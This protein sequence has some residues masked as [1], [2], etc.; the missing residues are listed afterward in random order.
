MLL[1]FRQVFLLIFFVHINFSNKQYLY[2]VWRVK[3]VLAGIFGFMLKRWMKTGTITAFPWRFLKSYVPSCLFSS[4]VTPQ[5]ERVMKSQ[6][7]PDGL[8]LW[9]P[10]SLVRATRKGNIWSLVTALP[11]KGNYCL[12]S[13]CPMYIPM[14]EVLNHWHLLYGQ[15]LQLGA[16]KPHKEQK[17]SAEKGSEI[18]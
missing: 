18:T 11:R 4:S 12:N 8:K 1:D 2:R 10:W 5:R 3:R 7:D 14:I 6:E 17:F 9:N 13:T 16:M 15:P